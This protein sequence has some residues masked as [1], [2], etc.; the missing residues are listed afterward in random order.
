MRLI[1]TA[2]NNYSDRNGR[3]PYKDHDIAGIILMIVSA[4]LLLCTLIPVMFGIV[5][6]TLRNFIMGIF[7]VFSYAVFAFT[8]ALGLVLLLKRRPAV[9]AKKL[10]CI[11]GIVFFL[12]LILQ[13]STTGGY[14]DE[15]FGKYLAD[16]YRAKYTA[17]GAF[18]G[19]I[20]YAVKAFA[21]QAGAYII[22]SVLLLLFI[23]LLGLI[24]RKEYGITFGVTRKKSVAPKDKKT[25]QISDTEKFEDKTPPQRVYNFLSTDLFV[26]NIMAQNNNAE[27]DADEENDGS[28]GRLYD[29]SADYGSFERKRPTQTQATNILYPVSDVDF[30]NDPIYRDM[31]MN[32]TDR[33]ED[34]SENRPVPPGTKFYDESEPMTEGKPASSSAAPDV[35]KTSEYE[36]RR[37]KPDKIFHEDRNNNGFSDIIIPT[38]KQEENDYNPGEIINS[39]TGDYN[40]FSSLGEDRGFTGSLSDRESRFSE[41]YNDVREEYE[42]EPAP[43][44][45]FAAEKNTESEDVFP[46]NEHQPYSNFRMTTSFGVNKRENS[47]INDS[48]IASETWLNEKEE[49]SVSHEESIRNESTINRNRTVYSSFSENQSSSEE[50]S[51]DSFSGMDSPSD[52]GIINENAFYGKTESVSE[53]ADK[54][55][56]ILGDGEDTLII[57]DDEPVNASEKPIDV[58]GTEDDYTG[59]YF[60]DVS[61]GTQ[62]GN[63]AGGAYGMSDRNRAERNDFGRPAAEEKQPLRSEPVKPV[64]EEPYIYEY[65]PV[66]L[67]SVIDSK[68]NV[69]AN[70]IEIKTHDI[71]EVLAN[72][73]F[74][75]KVCNVIVGPVVTRFELQPPQGIQVKKILGFEKD[76]ELTLER[77]AIRIEAPVANKK[78]IGIEV[79]NGKP[80]MVGLREMFEAPAFKDSRSVMPLAL[81]K[82]IGGDI[83]VRNLEKMPHLLVAGAT[84]TGK[85]VCLNT[86]ILSIIY[87]RSPED[88]RI[89]LVDPKQVE[90]TLY[91]RLPHLLL[92]NPITEVDQ[93]INALEYLT[94]EMNR[95]YELFSD[96]ATQ[97]YP[98][99]NLDEYN[100][101]EAVKSGKIKKMP[102]IVMIVDEL[103]DLMTSRKKEVELGIRKI[104]QKSRAAGIH[105]VLATQ[106]PSVDVITGTIKV[107]LPSRISFKVTSNADSRTVLDQGGAEA[108]LGNG[109]MLMM[110]NSEPIR[111][112]GAFVS[113]EEIVSVV[114][115]IKEHNKAEFDPEIA[116]A[117][118]STKEVPD[119]MAA[120]SGN[121]EESADEKLYPNIMRCFINSGKAS[122]S[123][124]QT[125]FS[126]GY[127]RAARILSIFEDRKWVGP[128]AG[129]KP[130]EV[131][132]TESQFETIFAR[133]FNE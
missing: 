41:T 116:D 87:K 107:N 105:L 66:S 102:Y 88:V 62:R 89:L 130:R 44:E 39:A 12:M 17:G 38:P 53:T 114:N 85:S 7:G 29:M 95:R 32:R 16:V 109:D 43:R 31:N 104:T 78:A 72:L 18:F 48:P 118:L 70:D 26:E 1:F 123:L 2:M 15:S 10:A 13:L 57:S 119:E 100:K 117:I 30:D 86:L 69:D 122:T 45:H 34:Y 6:K 63:Y 113:N 54:E 36:V 67:L 112:Q 121:A 20:A 74:P 73:K 56:K 125:R 4:F 129:A 120:S 27:Y 23:V 61:G 49:T 60:E 14:L 55:S 40:G 94:D 65:P 37:K 96:L 84:G 51:Y 5:S 99:R 71:E 9:S 64:K 50:T 46:E 58:Y 133:P 21:T 81:G 91:R 97:G 68:E 131:Y 47:V 3:R 83:I 111:L 93:A 28:S 103:A 8:F 77:G 33:R 59:R 98:V 82:D 25:T 128:S 35:H 24:I 52:E 127:A 115:Y 126:L 124:I 79:A 42:S 19:M 108:L 106:R 132:M 110:C 11:I 22:F 92:E 76:L 80:A 90:F 75:A 101:C